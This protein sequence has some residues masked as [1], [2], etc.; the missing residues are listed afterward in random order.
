MTDHDLTKVDLAE[1]PLAIGYKLPTS[2]YNREGKL[3]YSK[4]TEITS[5]SQID[6]LHRIDLFCIPEPEK[7]T[8]QQEK[9]VEA[10]E[11]KAPIHPFALLAKAELKLHSIMKSLETDGPAA[12]KNLE[13]L[14]SGIY[15]LTHK[16]PDIALGYC[17]WPYNDRTGLNQSV[18]CSALAAL[19]ATAIG[20]EKKRVIALIQG[21]LMQ[22]VSSW[23]FQLELNRQSGQLSDEQKT[24]LQKHPVQSAEML[25][26]IGI[27]DPDIINTVKY[28]HER[29][30]GS[31]YPFGLS[32]SDIPQLAKLVAIAD[33]YIAMT[34]Y[35]AYRDVLPTKVALREILMSNKDPEAELYGCFIKALGIYPPGTFVLL[36]NGETAVVIKRNAENSIKPI[37]RSI[38]SP[39][40]APYPEPT[41]HSLVESGLEIFRSLNFAELI[42]VNWYDLWEMENP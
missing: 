31:G 38:A 2:L 33:T 12:I 36:K 16:Y 20:I 32:G 19:G 10:V 24:K 1:L 4:G 9:P 40:G 15:R 18:I 39:N 3:L 35:R 22:N 6:R 13:G 14:A 28:H 17:H 37:V 21:A 23:E 34:T 26:S 27:D 30:D 8:Q 41:E 7:I 5:E 11:T 25:L 29:P 42:R